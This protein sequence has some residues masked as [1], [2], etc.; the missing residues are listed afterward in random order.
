MRINHKY[1]Y[2]IPESERMV[3]EKLWKMPEGVKQPELL[4]IFNEEGIPWKRQTLNTFISRL[5]GKGLVHRQNGVVAA[6]YDEAGYNCLQMKDAIDRLYGGKLTNFV[7]A[8]SRENMLSREDE[9][10]LLRMLEQKKNEE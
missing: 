7:A 3:M 6:S 10:E 9:D 4:G 5:E 2:Y 1:K 8:F